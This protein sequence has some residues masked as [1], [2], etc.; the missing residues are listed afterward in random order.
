MFVL[1]AAAKDDAVVFAE[2]HPGVRAA[3]FPRLHQVSAG[4]D[5]E[6]PKLF[7]KIV[8]SLNNNRSRAR[9][10]SATT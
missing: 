9:T 6:M 4:F 5:K 8:K 3:A 1:F 10:S 2:N 7:N